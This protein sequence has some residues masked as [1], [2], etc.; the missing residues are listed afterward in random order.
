MLRFPAAFSLWL[1]FPILALAADWPQFR[2]PDGQGHS[3]AT[4]LP[5][6]WSESDNIAWKTPI[7]GRGWSSPAIQGEQIWLTT[8]LDDGHSLHAV[9]INRSS[10]AM[11]HDVEV[12]TPADPGHINAK[13]SYASPTPI[14]EGDRVYTHF[15]IYGTA[16]LSN[17]GRVIWK[18]ED[19]KYNHG[20]GPGGSPVIWNDLIIFNCDGT[21]LQFMVA[22]DKNTGQDRWRRDRDHVDPERK[23]GHLDFALAYSTPLVIDVEGQ[24]QVV[25]AT[26]DY[27]AG[28]DPRTGEEIWYSSYVGSSNIPRP[29]YGKG[30][31]FVSSGYDNPV[32]YAVR[33]GGHG[34]VTAS[35][36]VWSTK[37]AAPLNPS[38]L[39]L[40]DELY[41]I[42]DKGIATC[43]DAT[44]GKQHWQQRIGGSFLASPVSAEG[45]IY[46]LDEDATVTVIA[47]G[48]E[49]K[50]LATNKLDGRTV[51]SPA[52]VDSAI[53]LRTDGF[54]YR[55]ERR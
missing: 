15:G 44:T 33:V 18:R 40:G 9:C 13:N 43:L 52:I 47:A 7:R 27:V 41:L 42:S 35:H 38:P 21:D 49:F 24:P 17:D 54:L 26:A 50:K 34:N 53:F 31:V 14:L 45:R 4:G 39:L 19:I 20:H 23:S 2:G 30:L 8:A 6:T 1:I 55:I 16:C 5:L 29:V 36:V 37:K 28:Y 51:A 12:F 22:L 25:S 10:G 11:M 3:S 32:F 48:K 46:L